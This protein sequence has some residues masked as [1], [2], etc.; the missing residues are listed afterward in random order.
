MDKFT[1]IFFVKTFLC[2]S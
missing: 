1:S 2:G